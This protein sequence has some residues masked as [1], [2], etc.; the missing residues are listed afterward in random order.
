MQVERHLTQ[1]DK[2]FYPGSESELET[3][4]ARHSPMLHPIATLSLISKPNS[5]PLV[6]CFVASVRS[7]WVYSPEDGSKT[8]HGLKSDVPYNI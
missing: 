1:M 4:A 2:W 3:D 8:L 6:A 7:P 5:Q